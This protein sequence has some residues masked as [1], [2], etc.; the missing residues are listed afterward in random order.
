MLADTAWSSLFQLPQIAIVAGCLTGIIAI[1]GVF[2]SHVEKTKSKNELKRSLVERGMS[3][4][5]IERIIEAG[6]EEKNR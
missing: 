4:E 6:E 3:V 5:E 1:A 2:W